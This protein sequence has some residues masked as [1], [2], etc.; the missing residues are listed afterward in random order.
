MVAG[1][2]EDVS[3]VLANFN[4][5]AAVLNGN[6][7]DAN[8]KA[9]AAIAISKLAGYPADVTRA[10]RGD[11]TWGTLTA[12]SAAL[13]IGAAN[14]DLAAPAG[15][16][17]YWVATAAGGT[18]RSIG[19]GAAGARITLK[20]GTAA[21]YIRLLHATAG[22]AGAQ[23]SIINAGHK[24]LA[25]GQSIELRYDGAVW[26]EVNRPARELICDLTLGGAQASFDTDTI[27]GI[28]NSLPQV[29]THL[30]LV[31]TNREDDAIGLVGS[32]LR[33]NNDATASYNWNYHQGSGSNAMASSGNIGDTRFN[34]LISMG[35]LAVA[36][37]FAQTT[38]DIPGYASGNH[39]GIIGKSVI[40]LDNTLASQ[41]TRVI[42]GIWRAAA[43]ISRIT[44]AP[45]AGNWVANSRFT[46]YG[47]T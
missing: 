21:G 18:L 6:I 16:D 20:N 38:L 25:P 9:A 26:Q 4:A 3:Q 28:A 19:A 36:T 17:N 45:V 12:V 42:S 43:A 34:N 31:L 37:R 2:P 24:F 8:I 30:H 44:F 46:L 27:L 13:N 14:T 33:F 47:D 7:D 15:S 11:G 41:F 5:I 29:Y 10:L 32:S 22:G 35:T 23:L 40:D 1:Q 39:K